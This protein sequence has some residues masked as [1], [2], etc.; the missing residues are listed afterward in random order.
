MTCPPRFVI[1]RLKPM[2]TAQA[3]DWQ[4]VMAILITA[5]PPAAAPGIV[6]GDG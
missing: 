4:S 1:R 2:S 6:G 5:A 3:A